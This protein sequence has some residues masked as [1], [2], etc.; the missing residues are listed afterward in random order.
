MK[1]RKV[2]RI[3]AIVMA[4]TMTISSVAPQAVFASEVS[5]E[6]VAQNALDGEQEISESVAELNTFEDENGDTYVEFGG[7]NEENATAEN[8]S[9]Q[10]VS[11]IQVVAP[12]NQDDSNATETVISN[13]SEV[14]T[15][16][17]EA[18]ETVSSNSSI[19]EGNNLDISDVAL[20]TKPAMDY[21][22]S[23]SESIFEEGSKAAFEFITDADVNAALP[24][25]A[26]DMQD[27]DIEAALA[28]KLKAIGA[29]GADLDVESKTL[30][31]LFHV[32]YDICSALTNAA[33]F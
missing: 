9:D 21:S 2:D 27:A 8:T 29:D 3:L 25:I 12:E 32:P 28:L 5:M 23:C 6:S 1:K 19:L 16:A 7:S 15:T 17:A 31:V 22:I 33:L 10:E 30:N 24:S 13:A 14:D 26:V 18:Q 11:E 20:G 4:A